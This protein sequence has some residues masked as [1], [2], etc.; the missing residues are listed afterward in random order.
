MTRGDRLRCEA[1]LSF[2]RTFPCSVPGCN[3]TDIVAHH[4]RIGQTGGMGLKPSDKCAV[5]L[6]NAHHHK[7]HQHGEARFWHG[8]GKDPVK[9]AEFLW[10]ISPA[11]SGGGRERLA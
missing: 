3:S 10:S 1:H 11:N 4:C 6:C 9:E 8:I 2:V 5:A 7:L